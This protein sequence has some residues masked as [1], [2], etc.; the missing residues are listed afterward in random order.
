MKQTIDLNADLAE[1]GGPA[2]TAEE[3][4]LLEIITSANIACGFHAGSETLMQTTCAAAQARDV[5]IGAHVSYH[6]REGFGRRDQDIS[7]AQLR[8]D[9]LQQIAAL[10]AFGRVAYVKPHGALYNRAAWDE[11]Q[12]QVIV[13][14]VMDYDRRL[15]VLGLPGSMLLKLAAQAGLATIAE[16]F[17]D[18]RYTAQGRLVPRTELGAVITDANLAAR[19]AIELAAGSQVRTLCVH[20]DTPGALE[21]AR[22]VRQGLQNA[23]FVVAAFA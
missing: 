15:P 19:Q 22:Q 6:D 16:G 1:S 8:G 21:L 13:E 5:R 12:A 14:A 9:M 23:G 20:G 11:Q 3:L 4:A 17:A 7:A 2:P 10:G 18:R